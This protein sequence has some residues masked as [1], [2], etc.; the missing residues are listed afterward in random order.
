[1]ETRGA[2]DATFVS[3]PVQYDFAARSAARTA[4]H[5]S[6]GIADAV[7]AIGTSLG[8]VTGRTVS[9]TVLPADAPEPEAADD[10]HPDV[11][12][13]LSGGATQSVVS[14]PAALVL[15][16]ADVFLGGRGMLGTD[17]AATDLEL[18]L[19][20]TRLSAATNSLARE[21]CDS[22]ANWAGT[23]LGES[24][25]PGAGRPRLRLLLSL[26]DCPDAEISLAPPTPAVPSHDASDVTACDAMNEVTLPLQAYLGRA[27]VTASDMADLAE[28]D[29]LTL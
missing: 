6:T 1:M 28:G 29:V 22:P 20:A 17:R 10:D 25:V 21:L 26:Q 16:L 9:C 13:V 18:E 2:A 7:E 4:L 3:V 19:V 24:P 14:L 27:V 5:I 23:V 15:R 12:F 11:R 8:V